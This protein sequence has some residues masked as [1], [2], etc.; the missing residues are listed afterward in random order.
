MEINP[1]S[2]KSTARLAGVLYL[3]FIILGLYIDFYIP[4]QITTEGAPALVAHSVLTNELLLRT[5]FAAHILTNTVWLFLVLVLYRLFKSVD[6]LQAKVMLVL[7]IVQIP[8]VFSL[9][10]LQLGSLMLFKGELLKEFALS[11]RQDLAMLFFQV[12]GLGNI[13]EQLFWGLWLF[14]LAILIYKSRFLPRFI[15]V[16]LAVNGFAYVV[17]SFTSLLLPQYANPVFN[18]S[19]PALIGE[20]VFMLWLLIMGAK[21]PFKENSQLSFDKEGKSV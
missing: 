6:R 19:Q 15:G 16:W 21:P 13:T 1:G 5:S 14:P 8:P 20:V 10:A 4:S 9:E 17:L 7:V 11:Q 18:Y 2:I 12:G 3:I